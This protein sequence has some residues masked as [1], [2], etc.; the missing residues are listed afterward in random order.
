MPLASRVADLAGFDLLLSVARTGSIGRAAAE[1]RISQPSA[2]ARLAH[3]ESRVGV[4]L[5]ERTP[6]GSRLTAEGALVADW[7]REAITAAAALESGIAALRQRT[8]SRLRVFAS[9]TIAEYALPAWLVTFGAATP[10][11]PVALSAGNS[12]QVTGAV[13]AGEADLGFIEGPSVS[14]LLSSREVGRDALV[15]VVGPAHPWARRRRG[16]DATELAT[17]PLISREAGSGTRAAL[18]RALGTA[19][20]TPLVEFS[21]TTAIKSAVTAGLGPAVLSS[22]AVAADLAGG[23][24]ISVPVAGLDLTRRLRAVWPAGQRLAG[25]A[26]DL[27]TIA[28]RRPVSP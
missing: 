19:A 16:I 24:L 15:V 23:S 18:D 5:L 13:V 7:A 26:K 2:S 11:T 3:L 20:V 4:P 1:H 12:A 28:G 27:L 17:T 6:R 10:G 14:K 22:L 8:S 9:M 21:S 25:P